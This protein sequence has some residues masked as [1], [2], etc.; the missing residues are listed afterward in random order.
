MLTSL[1]S[2]APIS[3]LFNLAVINL[4][5]MSN[6]STEMLATLAC[7]TA[8]DSDRELLRLLRQEEISLFFVNKS[9]LNDLYTDDS[10]NTLLGVYI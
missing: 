3:F 8:S 9:W 10:T 6:N 1:L 4:T 5:K 7:P 2:Q